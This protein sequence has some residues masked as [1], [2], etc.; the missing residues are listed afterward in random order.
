MNCLNTRA[1]LIIQKLYESMYQK[2]YMIR[3]GHHARINNNPAYMPVVI[4]KV[5]RLHSYGEVISIAHYGQQNGDPMAD[6]DMEF[7][8][9]CGDYYPI[10]YRNDYLCQRQDVFT[11]DSE[12][13]PERI[14]KILQEH[15]TSFANH[16]LKNSADQQ[17]L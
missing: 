5:G 17:S 1:K 3:E 11:L 12:G 7:V 4:E 13:K 10:S 6:P 9:V 15:L 14:N 16:W 8:I 2:P